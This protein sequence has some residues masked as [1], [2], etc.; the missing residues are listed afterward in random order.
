[1]ATLRLDNMIFPSREDVCDDC[2]TVAYDNGIQGYED[3]ADMMRIMGA[4]VEDHECIKHEG[5]GD[6]C[7]CPC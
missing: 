7:G 4:D 2:I 5:Q 3:Q 6:T 1:M